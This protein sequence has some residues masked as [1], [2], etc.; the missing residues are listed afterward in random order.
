MGSMC[1]EEEM[2]GT[3]VKGN[4]LMGNTVGNGI[5]QTWKNEIV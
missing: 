4:D 3:S 5:W 2:K 1:G